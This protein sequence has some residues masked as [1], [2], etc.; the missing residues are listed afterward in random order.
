MLKSIRLDDLRRAPHQTIH[1]EFRQF[2]DGFDSLAPV[3]GQVQ[4]VHGGSFL[5]VK[6]QASTIVT[7]TCH[8]CLQQFNHRL[9]LEFEEILILEEAPQDPLPLDLEI[10]SEDLAERIDPHGT[11]DL[12][13]WV[14][15]NLY[16]QMPERM[17]CR[18][19]CGGVALDPCLEEPVQDPRWA[20][21]RALKSEGLAL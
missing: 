7:L 11:F 15:Q 1:T 3:E 18:S 10:D 12:A 5:S 4:V 13:D 8:R 2:I 9:S 21:L 19:D 14:Y 16:L 20:A 17:A 6:G